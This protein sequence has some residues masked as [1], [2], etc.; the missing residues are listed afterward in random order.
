MRPASGRDQRGSGGTGFAVSVILITACASR[1]GIRCFFPPSTPPKPLAG[2]PGDASSVL[3]VVYLPG[4]VR[5]CLFV[6]LCV[7]SFARAGLQA[8]QQM[9]G[10]ASRVQPGLNTQPQPRHENLGFSSL[11]CPDPPSTGVSPFPKD[12]SKA[13]SLC[14]IFNVWRSA[15]SIPREINDSRMI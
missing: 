12:Q 3:L 14:P 7:G 9:C 5:V 11:P 4:E 15:A 1:C 6:C 13:F 2:G 10:S 8:A